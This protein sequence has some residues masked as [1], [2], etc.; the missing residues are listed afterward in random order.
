MRENNVLYKTQFSRA[1]DLNCFLIQF[2]LILHESNEFSV[3]LAIYFHIYNTYISLESAY[4]M[5]LAHSRRCLRNAFTVSMGAYIQ[6][7]LKRRAY[8][9]TKLKKEHATGIRL[10]KKKEC[11]MACEIYTYILDD[12]TYKQCK[13]K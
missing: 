11:Y 9:Q 7:K 4:Q 8:T 12:I 1:I 2:K 3:L 13:G 5:G 6:Y 10:C